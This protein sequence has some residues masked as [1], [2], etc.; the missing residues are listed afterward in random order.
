MGMSAK[1]CEPDAGASATCRELGLDVHQ[2]EVFDAPFDNESFDVIT[3]NH[4]I[5]HVR[6]PLQLLVKLYDLLAPGGVLWLALPNPGAI[7]ASIFGK[8]WNGL[9]PPFH[10]LIPSQRILL[11][12]LCNTGFLNARLVRRGAQ[13]SGMWRDSQALASR[14]GVAPPRLVT[15]IARRVGDVLSTFSSAWAEETIAMAQ[16]PGGDVMRVVSRIGE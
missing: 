5:E 11:K 10:L 4:V 13:S 9:S 8:G 16:K 7:G 2:G 12:W 3:L 6:Q 14:E 15:V 1:G